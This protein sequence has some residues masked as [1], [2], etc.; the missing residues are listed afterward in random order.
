MRAVGLTNAVVTS[1]LLET[2]ER[3][4]LVAYGLI[5]EFIGRFP[6][7]FSSSALNEDQLLQVLTEPKNALG[8]RY[9]RMFA[10]NNVKLHFIALRLI[11]KKAIAKNTGA[12]GL[13]PY[14]KMFLWIQCLRDGIPV[15]YDNRIFKRDVFVVSFKWIFKEKMKADGTIVKYKAKLV[16]KGFRQREGL[17]Y[18]D[19]YLPV[20]RITS[21]RMVLAISGLRKLEVHQ[22]D[23]KIYKPTSGFHGS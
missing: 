11:A 17:D 5:C 8:K 12:R 15:R 9:K 10:M 7:L 21:I 6:I 19:T 14:W 18:F 4:D 16:I 3:G 22:M 20:T 23:V 2:V 1:S 13:K